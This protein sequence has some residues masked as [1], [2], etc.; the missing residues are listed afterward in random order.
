MSQVGVFPG[1]P[2]DESEKNRFFPFEPADHVSPAPYG[3][4]GWYW[5]ATYKPGEKVGTT[6]SIQD[7]FTSLHVQLFQ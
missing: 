2:T 6:V 7:N 4:N 5:R 3:A 1:D